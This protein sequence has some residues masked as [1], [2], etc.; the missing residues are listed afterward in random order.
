MQWWLYGIKIKKSN[1]DEVHE[2]T[3]MAMGDSNIK[4][5]EIDPGVCIL[6]LKNKLYLF[7]KMELISLV[8]A[9][10]DAFHDLT[11]EGISCSVHL[12]W[13]ETFKDT[14]DKKLHPEETR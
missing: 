13:I 9:M 5:E 2:S 11:I 12:Y 14:T 6:D 7:S 3:L 1:D 8:N 4:E 10:I